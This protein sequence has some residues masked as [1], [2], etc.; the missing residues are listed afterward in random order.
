MLNRYTDFK[1][2]LDTALYNQYGDRNSVIL[3]SSLMLIIQRSVPSLR[4]VADLVPFVQL[5]KRQEHPWRSVTFSKDA[6]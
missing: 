3:I 1:I 6:G 5:K 2:A 4:C